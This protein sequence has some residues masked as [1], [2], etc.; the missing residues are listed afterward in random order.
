MLGVFVP[1]TGMPE[2]DLEKWQACVK[3]E[4]VEGVNIDRLPQTSEP[5]AWGA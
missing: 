1:V 4:M 5:W 3:G 2:C